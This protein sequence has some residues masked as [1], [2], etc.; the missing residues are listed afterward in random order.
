M[1]ST[2]ELKSDYYYMA[3]SEE[4][5]RAKLSYVTLL[6]KFEYTQCPFGLAQAPAYLSALNFEVLRELKLAFGYLDI[7]SPETHL[8]TWNFDGLREADL[9]GKRVHI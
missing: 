6:D 8:T 2:F 3:V 1:S 4:E 9:Q 7:L 5:S